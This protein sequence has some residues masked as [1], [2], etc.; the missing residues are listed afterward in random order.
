[1]SFVINVLMLAGPLYM[2]Q[3]Y[4]RV[5]T[6]RS[7]ETLTVLTG[8]LVGLYVFL[9]VLDV[10]RTRILSRIALRLDRLLGPELLAGVVGIGGAKPVAA[11]VQP[12]RD[13]EQ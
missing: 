4:D 8:L 11:E 9:G 2:L 13:L 7:L 10:I 6:S 3:V 5:L 12:M 1:I